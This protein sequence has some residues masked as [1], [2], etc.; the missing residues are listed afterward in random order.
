M[1]PRPEKLQTAVQLFTDV[2]KVTVLSVK[3]DNH[4]VPEDVHFLHILE[5]SHASVGS[6]I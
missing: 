3:A 6:Y 2:G 4:V 1:I 5:H